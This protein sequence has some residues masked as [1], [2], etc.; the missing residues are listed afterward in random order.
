M[1][2]QSEPNTTRIGYGH[3]PERTRFKKGQSGNPR[4]RPKGT[5]NVATALMKTLREKVVITENGRRKTVSK[6]EAAFKQ[7]VNLAAAGDLRAIQL[8]SG[9]ARSVEERPNQQPDQ[10]VELGEAD[11][12]VLE[13]ILRRIS[14]NGCEG[15]ENEPNNQ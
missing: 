8:L 4:G 10:Q 5:L 15:E 7:L 2:K 3:P 9:L 14:K 13:S 1:Q 11:Q 6:L 12:K